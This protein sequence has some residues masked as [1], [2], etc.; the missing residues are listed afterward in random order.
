MKLLKTINLRNVSGDEIKTYK[1]RETSRGILLDEDEKIAVIYIPKY[2][3]YQLVGGGIN[4]GETEEEGLRRE[5]VEE[6]GVE[7]E[8]ISELGLI[9]EIIKENNMIQNSYCYVS[10]VVGKKGETDF[11]EEEKGH[12][13][14]IK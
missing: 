2:D 9:R 8:I 3:V 14:E 5:C 1:I 6:A 11:T 10:R 12:G 4:E 13:F 7:I